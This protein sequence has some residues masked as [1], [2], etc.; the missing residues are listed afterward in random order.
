[1]NWKDP[2]FMESGTPKQKAAFRAVKET[3]VLEILKPFDAT[4]V[5][6]INIGLDTDDSDL[7]I[8]CEVHD[9]DLFRQEL[10][11]HFSTCPNYRIKTRSPEKGEIICIFN[12]GGFI[13]EIFGKSQ[14]IAEQNAFRHLSI[15]QHLLV[16]GGESLRKQVM[17][18]R[19]AGI[20]SE[21]AFARVLGIKGDPYNAMLELEQLNDHQLMMLLK[22]SF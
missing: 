8:I 11:L 2:T 3:G 5:S 7:D 12:H 9:P 16:L 13:F 6:T 18:L 14:P 10:K 22:Q 17:S 4:L 15:M 1:M 19:E 20:K 21:P